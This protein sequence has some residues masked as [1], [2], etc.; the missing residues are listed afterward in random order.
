M[1]IA[2]STISV[3]LLLLALQVSAHPSQ[4]QDSFGSLEGLTWKTGW[5]PLGDVTADGKR[6]ATGSDP[7]STFMTGVYELV[8]IKWDRRTPRLP[9]VGA[10]I[11]LTGDV[12]IHILDYATTGEK[13]RMDPPPLSSRP[14]RPGDRTG[15]WLPAGTV[16][17][18]RSVKISKPHGGI[19]GIWAR[20]VPVALEGEAR[21]GS[22][23]R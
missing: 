7:N 16:V 8:G 18:V 12:P 13:R 22:D 9:A 1:L 23:E 2:Q 14:L 20:V 19:R 10:R 6:W 17:E 11:R 5:I 15:I 21:G 4:S 3:A